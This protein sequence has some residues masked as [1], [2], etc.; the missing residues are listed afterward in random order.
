MKNILQSEEKDSSVVLSC[1]MNFKL[2]TLCHIDRYVA[3]CH[4]FHNFPTLLCCTFIKARGKEG[5]SFP[6][7][8]N[9]SFLKRRKLISF[10]GWYKK[11]KI[12][13]LRFHLKSIFLL[14]PFEIT[15]NKRLFLKKLNLLCVTWDDFTWN[16]PKILFLS[17]QFSTILTDKCLVSRM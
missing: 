4:Y 5:K 3:G 6:L 16:F 10:V 1:I 13:V 14:S 2:R 8:I 11:M 9:F 15:I 17:Q 12:S 7:I